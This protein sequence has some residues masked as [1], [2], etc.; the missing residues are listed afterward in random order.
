MAEETQLLRKIE[1]KTNFL[2][3][4]REETEEIL[5][6]N[7]HKDIVR[8]LRIYE[9]K[10]DEIQDIKTAVQEL[11]LEA[12]EHP[13]KVR[14]WR[15]DLEVEIVKFQP[16]IE[17]LS[18]ALHDFK[19]REQHEKEEELIQAKQRQ[20]E[21]EIELEKLKF[22]QRLEL[23]AKLEEVRGKPEATQKQIS[24]KLPKLEITKF[25][26]THM[27][28]FRFWSQFETEVDK[29]NIDPVTKF[30]YL[31]EF[32]EPKVRSTIENLNHSSEGYE[33]AKQ[34]LK[35]KYGKPSEVINAH[36]Q[37]IMA[38]PHIRGSNPSK[39]HDFFNKLLPSAQALESMGKLREISGYT[40]ATLD[41]L[42]GIRADLVRLDDE[43]QLW[44][45]P[46]LVGGFP[47]L[48]RKEL[49]WQYRLQT[50]L[51][52]GLNERAADVEYI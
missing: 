26:G 32:L 22:K 50:F 12:G 21:M 24:V 16:Y 31:K 42:E 51:P 30:N 45:F 9:S 34:I 8:Q 46:Q 15:A 14:K 52:K 47:Q 36:V 19:K 7:I 27:D 11:K 38:L 6:R 20:F 2:G 35:S 48:R 49:F 23:E 28:W 17:R 40:R 1:G 37:S 33:R 25:R 41:K 29:Q 18:S 43:W 13:D 39:I 5:G 10:L 44:G 4:L 3:F